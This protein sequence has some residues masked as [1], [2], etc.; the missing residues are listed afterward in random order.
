MERILENEKDA[1]KEHAEAR[2]FQTKSR[3]RAKER[4]E[5][6][7]VCISSTESENEDEQKNFT[8]IYTEENLEKETDKSAIR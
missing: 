7:V 4:N 6:R 2:N 5:E 3:D 8:K 1:D